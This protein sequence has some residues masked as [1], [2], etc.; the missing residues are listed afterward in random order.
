MKKF[1]NI[2][3]VNKKEK[4]KLSKEEKVKLK[5]EKTKEKKELKEK[6]KESKNTL[7]SNREV[8][9]F[10]DVDE[11]NFFVTKQGF[12]NLYQVKTRDVSNLSEY[13]TMLYIY[14]FI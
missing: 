12:L 1:E 4:V 2:K 9:P 7:I 11:D 14:N 10:L 13:E 5:E 8:L 3:I 6:K